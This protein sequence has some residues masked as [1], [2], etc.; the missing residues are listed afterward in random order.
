MSPRRVASSSSSKTTP[1]TFSTIRSACTDQ[2]LST[3]KQTLNGERCSRILRRRSSGR[4]LE[5]RAPAAHRRRAQRRVEREVACRPAARAGGARTSR[6]GGRRTTAPAGP[7]RARSM[8]S[9]RRRC[10]EHARP[11]RRRARSTAGR[12]LGRRARARAPSSPGPAT[13]FRVTSISSASSRRRRSTCG[14]TLGGGRERVDGEAVAERE[15]GRLEHV[16]RLDLV[17]PG[18]RGDRLRALDDRDVGAVAARRRSRRRAARPRRRAGRARAPTPR[19]ASAAAT[20]AASSACAA[21]HVRAERRPGSAAN[22]SRRRTTS[23]RA[24]GSASAS[25]STSSPIRSAICGRS[26][27]S[28][29]FIVPTSRNRAGCDDRDAFALDDVDAERGRVEQDVRQVVVEQVDLVDVEDPAVRLGEQ[30]RLER[31]LALLQRPGDVDAAGR[32]DPRSR[33]AAGRRS[34]AA[35]ATTGSSSP[36]AAP[37]TIAHGSC[38]SHEN[39]QSATTSI[40]GRSSASPRTAVDLPVPLG[41]LIRTPPTAGLTALSRSACLRR[42][43][44]TIAVNGK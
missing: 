31:P 1:F 4:D 37:G 27:P 17:A 42:S 44:S 16:V 28:S 21:A 26:S 5:R 2:L 41:P 34:A 3:T 40:S 10:V 20:A 39:G 35:A 11:G 36:R 15:L 8:R 7:S 6:A 30:P 19:R 33:S 22:A 12:A 9:R 13:F 38:G 23:A 25:T 18:E 43:C 14:S 24:S 32:R 29:S